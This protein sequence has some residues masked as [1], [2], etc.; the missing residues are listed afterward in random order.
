MRSH[1][2]QRILVRT[3]L[4]LL[5][6]AVAGLSTLAK[7]GKYLPKFNPLRHYLKATKM[8]LAHHPV[9]FIPAPAQPASR[10]V[11]PKPEFSATL[12]VRPGLTFRPIDLT[13]SFQHRAPPS[14]FA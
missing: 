10:V 4:F 2:P 6:I 7:Q 3:T 13:I 14:W 12:S 11:P 9:D 5:L 1:C 8:E